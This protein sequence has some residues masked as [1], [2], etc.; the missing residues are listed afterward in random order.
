MSKY[1]RA[2]NGIFDTSKGI[3]TS[4]I[5][6]WAI[7]S[8]TIYEKDIIKESDNIEDLLEAYLCE[9]KLGQG[10]CSRNFIELKRDALHG[11]WQQYSI[12]GKNWDDLQFSF[13]GL[14]KVNHNLICVA[15]YNEDKKEWELI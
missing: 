10:T 9:N 1:I 11:V 12:R 14:I 3:Y 15:E 6:M 7:G 2:E 5:K 8:A 4:S 13:Y